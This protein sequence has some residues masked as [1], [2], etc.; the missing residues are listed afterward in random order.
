VGHA[1]L[2]IMFLSVAQRVR[3]NDLAALKRFYRYFWLFFF[4]EYLLFAA[5]VFF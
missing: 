2:G 3:L 1:V 4:A 5:A